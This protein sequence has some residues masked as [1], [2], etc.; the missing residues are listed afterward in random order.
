M[1]QV[2][3]SLSDATKDRLAFLQEYYH[4]PSISETVSRL[5]WYAAEYIDRREEIFDHIKLQYRLEDIILVFRRAFRD[6][7][8]FSPDELARYVKDNPDV[9]LNDRTLM[10]WG[11]KNGKLSILTPVEGMTF[12]D[13]VRKHGRNWADSPDATA[14]VLESASLGCANF[15][16][17]LVNVEKN[18]FGE[19]MPEYTGLSFMKAIGVS[20]VRYDDLFDNVRRNEC[21]Y[22]WDA[23][24]N[25]FMVKF[26]WPEP[27]EVLWR[28]SYAE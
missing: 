13:V 3:M 28:H 7:N 15:E 27:K 19:S 1:G 26:N 4:Y 16:P 23:T 22:I 21:D 18:R 14:L 5:A 2:N 8:V 9:E 11:T 24:N 6:N 12:L 17:I 10:V 20:L 25:T